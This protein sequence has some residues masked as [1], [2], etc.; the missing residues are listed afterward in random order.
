MGRPVL[1]DYEKPIEP[2]AN[3]VIEHIDIKKTRIKYS[4]SPLRWFILASYGLSLASNAYVMMNFS[5]VSI[6]IADI[7]EVDSLVVSFNVMIFLISFIAFNFVS[8]AAIEKNISITF[9]LSAF[10][11]VF[12]VW[13][14]W[15][16]LKYTGNFYYLVGF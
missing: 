6:D 15:I 2:D 10:F 16:A 7:Y 14:R 9:K 5:P 13:G 1:E 12:G 4:T 3:P 11:N 8:V